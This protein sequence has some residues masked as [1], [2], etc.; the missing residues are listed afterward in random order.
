MS[1]WKAEAF[2][3]ATQ[4]VMLPW[5]LPPGWHGHGVPRAGYVRGIMEAVST[6]RACWMRSQVGGG[7][8]EAGFWES[9]ESQQ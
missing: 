4:G 7:K 5:G 6:G 2:E 9:R 3:L 1:G 8:Q